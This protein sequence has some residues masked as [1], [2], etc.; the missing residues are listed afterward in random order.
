V[1]EADKNDD[2]EEEG[3]SDEDDTSKEWRLKREARE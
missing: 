3:E 1:L 2:D